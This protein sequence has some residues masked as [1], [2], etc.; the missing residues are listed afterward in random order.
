[1]DILAIAALCIVTAIIAKTIQPT[2]Q[3]IAI[4]ITIAGVTAVV[5]SIIGTISDVLYEVQNLAG[6]SDISGTYIS[7]VFRVLGI[8]YVCEISSSCCRDCGESAL[9]SI[10]DIAG[11]VAVSVICLPLIKSFIQTIES[12]LELG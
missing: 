4:V 12:I 5:F 2:N 8:C 9:A 10:I 11:R 1:M 6:I 7:I 3:D